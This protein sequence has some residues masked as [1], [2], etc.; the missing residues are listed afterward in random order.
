MINVER[1]TRKQIEYANPKKTAGAIIFVL[2]FTFFVAGFFPVQPV[3][4]MS[5]SMYP[6]I[7]RGD[8]VLVQKID[9]DDIKNLQV[10]QVIEYVLE[11]KAVVHRIVAIVN[12]SGGQLEFVTKGDNNKSRDPKSVSESQITGKV[13]FKIPYIGYP[14]VIFSEKVLNMEAEFLYEGD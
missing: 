7:K 4:I 1:F 13:N 5:N 9:H 8:V 12:S 3:A 2:A 6:E 14:S 11:N 10:G